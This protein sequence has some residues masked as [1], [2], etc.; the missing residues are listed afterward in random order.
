MRKEH[1]HARLPAQVRM[2]SHLPALVVSQGQSHLGIDPLENT[3][4]AI[5]R[6]VRCCVVQLYQQREQRRAL[7]KGAYL[8]AVKRAFDQVTLPVTGYWPCLSR[9]ATP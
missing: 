6:A 8:R 1:L 5:C 7:D 4:K 3:N 2:V 9:A